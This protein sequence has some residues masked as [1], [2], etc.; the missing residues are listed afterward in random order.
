MR[1]LPLM[2]FFVLFCSSCDRLRA[3][4][5]EEVTQ[6][7]DLAQSYLTANSKPTE[8]QKF[9][10]IVANKIVRTKIEKR[11]GKVADMFY[12][13]AYDVNFDSLT[14]ADRVTVCRYLVFCVKNGISVPDAMKEKLTVEQF[15]QFLAP[16]ATIAGGS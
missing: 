7:G 14:T 12:S 2:M 3:V 4:A 5:S 11:S 9:Y 8:D 13:W 6:C 1:K 16:A 10:E 15:T